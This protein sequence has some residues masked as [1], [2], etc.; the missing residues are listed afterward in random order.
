MAHATTTAVGTTTTPSAEK[1][2]PHAVAQMLQEGNVLQ[3][4]R[5]PKRWLW[6]RSLRKVA[7]ATPG[8]PSPKRRVEKREVPV[9]HHI[10]EGDP[11]PAKCSRTV[12][13]FVRS[14]VRL[15][16]QSGQNK[17]ARRQ[18]KR[19]S[20]HEGEDECPFK[21]PNATAPPPE[22]RLQLADAPVRHGRRRP[23]RRRP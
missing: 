8:C 12:K 11:T 4:A 3:L 17:R 22:T 6:Q 2:L 7:K 1:I 15:Y 10:R 18:Q 16:S 21:Q 14:Q 23:R 5:E 9:V 19:A 20:L 13:H